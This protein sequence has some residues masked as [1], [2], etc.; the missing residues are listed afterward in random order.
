MVT[1]S[2][3]SGDVAVAA[4]HIWER[5]QCPTGREEIHWNLAIDELSSGW[6]AEFPKFAELYRD[7]AD[8]NGYGGWFVDLP[9]KVYSSPLATEWFENRESELDDLE[10]TTW[11]SVK[12]KILQSTSGDEQQLMNI[13][14]EAAG[15]SFLRRTLVARGI[16]FDTIDEPVFLGQQH[17]W[18]ATCEGRTVAALEAKTVP[19]F[20]EEEPGG[21]WRL[22]TVIR[23]DS[24]KRLRR[25]ACRAKRQLKAIERGSKE[26]IRIAYII[27]PVVA[28]QSQRKVNDDKVASFVVS[29][30]DDSVEVAC[31]VRRWSPYDIESMPQTPSRLSTRFLP[32]SV[33]RFSRLKS[34][35]YRNER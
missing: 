25:N 30:S 6:Q 4:Y 14:N 35:A 10:G 9:S 7:I 18:K 20:A 11:L 17:R 13:L 32:R 3:S 28:D 34:A 2:F 27:V 8:K 12:S 23:P 22:R 1:N 21:R 19:F 31:D 33:P 24:W 5:E 29:K 16:P 26:L 15:Y